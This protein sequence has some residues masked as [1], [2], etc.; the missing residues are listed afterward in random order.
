MMAAIRRAT[1]SRSV[2]T[3]LEERPGPKI[4]ALRSAVTLEKL[5]DLNYAKMAILMM[6]TA[7][8]RRELLKM[9]TN[10]TEVLLPNQTSDHQYEEM[11]F[12]CP[13]KPATTQ[14]T[15]LTMAE[16][17]HVLSSQASSEMEA[18]QPLVMS[19]TKFEVTVPLLITEQ[20]N[21]MT[22]TL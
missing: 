13:V 1:Q 22:V 17:I 21:E 5:S 4:I 9:G 6:A 15:S 8:A 3:V 2:L 19:V 18:T 20:T 7:A 12:E 11:D 10:E 14:T 16:T